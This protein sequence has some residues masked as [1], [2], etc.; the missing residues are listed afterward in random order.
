MIAPSIVL[1]VSAG[2]LLLLFAVAA[3]GDRRAAQGRSVIGNA[4]IFALSWAVYCSAWTYFGSVG[5]AAAGGIWFLPIYLGPMLAMLLAWIVLRKMVRIAQT[6]RITS[7]ADFIASRYGKSPLLAAAVTLITVVGI[8]PYI[9]LQLKA[10][11]AGYDLL[12]HGVE[13]GPEAAQPWWRN[14]TFAV[15]LVLA[16]FTIVFG[17]RHL[18]SAE[19]HEGMVAAIAFESVVK[20]GAFLA[21]GIF[22]TWGIFAGPA[23]I[24]A[25]A[26]VFPELQSLMR[27]GGGEGTAAF[28]HAQ[29]F[30]TTILAM[31]SVLLLP[32]Q[33]Q[34]MVVECVDEHHIRRAAWMFSGYLLLINLFVLPLAIGGMVHFGPGGGMDPETFVLSLPLA[35]GATVLALVAYIGGM[36][37]ATG[38]LIVETV[39]VSTMVCN[40]FVMPS[41]LRLRGF[42]ARAGGDLTELLL[43]IRRAAII[44]VLL[45][46]YLYYRIAGDAYAL[47]SIGLISFAAVAQFAPALLG[48]IYWR[49]GT[50]AGA[51]AGLLG[52]FAVWAY[53]LMLPSMAKSGWLPAAFLDPGPFGIEL[54]A[55]EALPG[56]T[57][58]D[59][60]THSLFWSLLVNVSLYVGI[61]L[62]RGPGAREASQ[63]LLF[64]D[65]F[66]QGDD[67]AE[68]APIFWRGR[69]RLE[70]LVDLSN[71][72][73]G[74]LRARQMFE[75]YAAETGVADVE[76]IT[77]DARL[78]DRV[79][80][81][82]AG[83]V[84][85]A[86]ARVMVASV[87][88]EEPLGIA[89]VIEILDEASQL[90]VYARA[91][92]EKSLSLEAATAE[93]RAANEALQSLDHMKD[94]FMS[95]VTH[96][97]RT[98][99]TSIRALTELMLDTPDMEAEQREKFLRIVVSE[100]ERM[101]R[102]VN[103]VLDMAKMESGHAEWHNADVDM[104]A[105]ISD[106]VTITAEVFRE[107]GAVAVADLPAQVPLIRA[108][109]D[110]LT[111]VML[112]LLTNAAK[113]VPKETG[114]A[115][116][117]L[118]VRAD[119]LVVTV[120]DNGPGIPEAQ[121]A[122][123]FERF[124]QVGDAATRPHGTGLGLPISRR[125]VEH[126]GGE[127]WVEA[128]PGGGACFAFRLPLGPGEGEG[129]GHQG[130]DCR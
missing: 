12:V 85:S 130:A 118:R 36:S 122:A 129:H 78:V 55:P 35:E 126:S 4:W 60:L 6:Y 29:W 17:T 52:G 125:I 71:R 58:L 59:N 120:R 41:L 98:P 106:A 91:L 74:P 3:F 101:S 56:L 18:D 68:P 8:V 30:A 61:S 127:M 108:D 62:W 90:R 19:R 33:F 69:A 112:N 63:A 77:A 24:W 25:R 34:M 5:R 11:S 80:R 21:V 67:A 117:I 66:E 49:G 20:L 54:L 92:E 38:M 28:G 97:L 44:A 99:L 89:D 79:E 94:D 107:R 39:A 43:N 111:Q 16:A 26:Q 104:R 96:E 40:D 65:V 42:D 2:Y 84:G 53:T 82:L 1:A 119:D 113:F 22:V 9:A 13:Q 15:T 27:L 109:P 23:D 57:G 73:L 7:I 116:V 114:R 102:L 51:L 128:A 88:Q 124:R 121:R 95:S 64:V 47:V 123:V 100:S 86:S 70:D 46:G 83:A 115:E 93:L 87:V 10:V 105:L 48:G 110:R 76:A 103:Q 14:G 50:A 81:Q 45:L 37:A 72:L 75:D 31:F 32:R